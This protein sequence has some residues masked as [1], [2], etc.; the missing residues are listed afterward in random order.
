M[1]VACGKNP[2]IIFADVPNKDFSVRVDERYPGV[3]VQHVSPFVGGVPVQFAIASGR[4][5]HVDA[6]NV[7]GRGK[8][9]R[10]VT[11][12]CRT[13]LLNTFVHEVKR[14]PDGRLRRHGRSREA[15]WSLG[16]GASRGLFS[17]AGSLEE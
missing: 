4:E 13:T 11:W 14:K 5:P 9:T 10:W 8:L 6:G 16:F 12:M 1:W 7:L 2:Q 15:Y 17:C 3:A